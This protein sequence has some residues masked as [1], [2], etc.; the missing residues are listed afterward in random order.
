MLFIFSLSHFATYA[1]SSVHE[2]VATAGNS[3]QTNNI[4]IDWTLGEVA[5]STLSGSSS[6]LTQGFH[7]PNYIITAT[8]QLPTDWGDIKIYPNPTADQLNINFML[9]KKEKVELVLFDLA[10]KIIQKNTF[11]GQKIN[12]KISLSAIPS[13]TYFLSMKIG[14]QTFSQTHKIQKIN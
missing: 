2:V 5:I 3:N 1:Q 9:L 10:G 14:N 13:G 8:K 7:Q 12:K 4:Q 11:V 6:L